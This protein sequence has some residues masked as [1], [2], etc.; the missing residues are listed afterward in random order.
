M[1]GRICLSRQAVRSSRSSGPCHVSS[2]C[3]AFLRRHC[4]PPAMHRL[5]HKRSMACCIPN[6]CTM[7][8][9]ARSA[10]SARAAGFLSDQL[11]NGGGERLRVTAWNNQAGVAD[12]ECSVTDVGGDRRQ[13]AS[14]PSPSA[15]ENPS[16]EGRARDDQISRGQHARRSARGPSA[17]TF[18][19]LGRFCVSLP[20]S[21]PHLRQLRHRCQEASMI[22]HRIDA[23]HMRGDDSIARD[24]ELAPHC[25]ACGASG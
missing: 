23:R 1:P 13:T 7:R 9:R 11:S 22:F 20:I 2:R 21:R 14:H 8:V 19:I 3:R 16:P 10:R 6:I 15:L 24:A 18:G 5:L 12:D 25:H 4:G 17:S